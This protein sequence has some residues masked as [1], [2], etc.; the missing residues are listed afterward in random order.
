MS[1][2]P[3]YDLAGV[4]FDDL[5]PRRVLHYHDPSARLRAL[6][7][8][9]TI[10]DWPSGGGVRM[11]PDLTL[12]EIA[13]LG[14]AMTYKYALLG[15]PIGGAKA[16]IWLDPADPARDEVVAAFV[17]AIRPLVESGAFVP[18][19]DM[20]T[21]GADF[22][23]PLAGASGD[24]SLDERLTGYGVVVAARTASELAGRSLDGASV[25]L[26]GFGKVGTSA[27][28]FFAEE[29]ARVVAVSTVRSMVHHPDGLDVDAMIALREE[30][31]DA[32]IERLP[33]ARTMPREALF[34]TDV[35]VL[36]PGARPDAVNRDNVDAIRA[37]WIVPGSNV[38]YAEGTLGALAER[39]TIALPDFVTN[40]GGVLATIAA[41]QGARGDAALTLVRDAI[42]RN[43]R[44]VS[45]R[46][47]DTGATP[48]DAGIS[49]AREQ[50]LGTKQEQR[51]E[52]EQ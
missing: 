49:I 11:A 47:R 25:A 34:E 20:G 40:A 44:R 50:L 31:G 41:L 4:R 7:V 1:R 22:P 35:D 28:R 33:G 36:V 5:G 42:E 38:P 14:R 19:P 8:I 27:A 23:S 30:H 13:R 16:G 37:R 52:T 43:V 10:R 32:G 12:T 24:A 9:D 21:K 51:R 15:M 17:A 48:Y 39:G 18:G 2:T 3:P 29:G 45:E 46:A 6:V 26:E